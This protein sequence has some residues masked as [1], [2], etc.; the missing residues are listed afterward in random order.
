MKKKIDLQ[1]ILGGEKPEKKQ[2]QKKTEK[3]ENSKIN[4]TV[5]KKMETPILLTEKRNP[6]P[7]VNKVQK[8][9]DSK[10]VQQEPVNIRQMKDISEKK[11]ESDIV[12][13]YVTFLL[14]KEEYA[15]DS[16]FVRQIIKY[17]KTID[18]GL[19][20][21]LFFGVTNMKD[22]V[23]PLVDFRKKFGMSEERKE[24][25]SIIILQIDDLRVGVYVDYLVGIVRFKDSDI[26]QIPPFLPERQLAYVTGIGIKSGKFKKIIIILNHLNLFTRDD[27]REM[28]RIPEMY[29]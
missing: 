8:K 25:G 5:E 26:K 14:K 3:R 23:L 24:E 18:I 6:D 20:S 21:D 17:K 19:K 22:G 11:D 27:I 16:D 10:T 7:V 28:K 9:E 4:A 12:K 13:E 1:E 15:I 29:K 2:R